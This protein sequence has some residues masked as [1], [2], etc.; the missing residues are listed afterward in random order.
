M[1][2]ISMGGT[3]VTTKYALMEIPL[4]LSSSGTQFNFPLNNY[5]T[6]KKIYCIE[7]Y[8]DTDI[9]KSPISNANL[10]WTIDMV[11][12]ASITLYCFEPGQQGG[13][14]A[15]WIKEMPV[16]RMHNNFNTKAADTSVS[17]YNQFLLAGQILD[18]N[19]CYINFLTAQT[20]SNNYSALFGVYYNDK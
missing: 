20:F 17:N 2:Q 15:E 16:T 6:G 3:L 5:V 1:S 13:T 8:I 4:L 10:T 11:K 19:K 12:Q 18:L 14:P 9:V 7:T